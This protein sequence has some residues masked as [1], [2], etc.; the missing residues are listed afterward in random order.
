MAAPVASSLRPPV[1]H[2]RFTDG[3]AADKAEKDQKVAK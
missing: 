3:N 2:H 1:G